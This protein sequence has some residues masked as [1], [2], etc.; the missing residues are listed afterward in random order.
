MNVSNMNTNQ[1]MNPIPLRCGLAIWKHKYSKNLFAYCPY[2][3]YNRI[4]VLE[5]L[6]SRT[7][8]AD[9]TIDEFNFSDWIPVNVEEYKKVKRFYKEIYE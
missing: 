5:E 9:T 2:P 3:I 8:L 6:T 4:I 7:V 1:Q